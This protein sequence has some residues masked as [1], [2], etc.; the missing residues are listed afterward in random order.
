MAAL[1]ALPQKVL[2]IAEHPLCQIGRQHLR[3]VVLQQRSRG[4]GARNIPPSVV[5]TLR[6]PK[7][8][9]GEGLESV[10]C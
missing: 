2:T 10:K 1:V 5:G 4:S 8:T 9:K 3:Q 7:I 6:Q